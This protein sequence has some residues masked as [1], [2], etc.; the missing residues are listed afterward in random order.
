M[1]PEERKAIIAKSPVKGK[2]DQALD[3][4]SAFEVLQG[5]AK[6]AAVPPEQAEAHAQSQG[7]GGIFGGLERR[8]RRHLRHRPSRGANRFR[9]ANTSRAK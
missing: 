1:S 6:A 4:E 9:P 2:Y 7:V 3:A 5:R 8:T